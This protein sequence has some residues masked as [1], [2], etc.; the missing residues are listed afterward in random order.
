[1]R[2]SKTGWWRV[3][4]VILIA[5]AAFVVSAPPATTQSSDPPQYD[6]RHNL[7]R[8]VG[9]ETWVF[10]G[11]NL[12][13]AYAGEEKP[14]NPEFHNVFMSPQAYAEFVKT[15]T[16]PDLTV[17]VIDRRK[18]AKKDPNPNP[19]GELINGEFNDTRVGIEVAVKN[20]NRPD[21]SKTVWAYYDFSNPNDPSKLL[22]SAEA[23]PDANCENCHHTVNAKTDNVWVQ[24]YPILRDMKK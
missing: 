2:V 11:S 17:F 14:K 10:V 20:Q 8:P 15:Q 19:M 16:F 23:Q 13:L 18:A 4:I 21:G 12:G 22:E 6:S 7:L 1:M 5:G 9:F 24:F 3:G